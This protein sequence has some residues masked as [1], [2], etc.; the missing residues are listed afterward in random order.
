MADVEVLKRR[1][2][3]P[4]FVWP[5]VA[6]IAVAVLALAGGLGYGAWSSARSLIG[7]DMRLDVAPAFTL[8]N[9]D[10]QPVSLS[11]FR[12]KPVVI[13]FLYTHCPDVCPI[14]AD[15]LHVASQQLGA[16]ASKVAI[17]AI[18]TDPT[19]DDRLSIQRFSEVHGMTG[20]WDYL[21]G[22]PGQLEPLW[23]AYYVA[24]QPLPD[25]SVM[26][27]AAIYIIDKEG[28]ERVFIDGGDFLPDD[29]VHDLR[30]LM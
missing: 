21:I 3:L 5:L 18:T 4:P 16:D 27:T 2:W 8:I 9:Q 14:I 6:L 7:T 1:A 11:D 30:L 10:G 24:A 15:K 17:L 25:S 26:H 12:G 13:T 20:R 22:S 29:V 23:K 19:H 28:R